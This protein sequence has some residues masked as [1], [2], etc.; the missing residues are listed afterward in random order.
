EADTEGTSS[1]FRVYYP[2]VDVSQWLTGTGQDQTLTSGAKGQGGGPGATGTGVFTT[3]IGVEFNEVGNDWNMQVYRWAAGQRIKLGAAYIGDDPN[4]PTTYAF[5]V[6]SRIAAP[7][8]KVQR[9]ASDGTLQTIS[10]GPLERALDSSTFPEIINQ[11]LTS[12]W[13][14]GYGTTKI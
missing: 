11:N 5:T 3:G 2:T 8:Y 10:N 13:F 7:Y 4:T 1:L 9:V 12:Q 14:V 6:D